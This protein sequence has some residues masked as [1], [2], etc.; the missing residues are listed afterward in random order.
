[1]VK[2]AIVLPLFI[3]VIPMIGKVQNIFSLIIAMILHSYLLQA[4]GIKENGISKTPKESI[5][6]LFLAV[7]KSLKMLWSYLFFGKSFIPIVISYLN[8]FLNF[9]ESEC[10][11]I[12]PLWTIVGWKGIG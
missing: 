2:L 12:T 11:S 8:G 6:N 9:T 7:F 10:Y 1:M 4:M 5:L 3:Y